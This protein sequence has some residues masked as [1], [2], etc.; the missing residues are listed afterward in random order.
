MERNYII[1]DEE[2][3]PDLKSIIKVWPQV[4]L[5]TSREV[6]VFNRLVMDR[7]RKEIAE[8]LCV[9][10]N[11]VKKHVSNIFSKLDVSSKSEI[12][13]MVAKAYHEE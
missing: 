6:E 13:K 7:R 5:L 11:T 3:L 4:S 9:S 12:V 2:N 10:E 8:E 1:F